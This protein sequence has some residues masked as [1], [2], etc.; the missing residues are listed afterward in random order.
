MT[1]GQIV[2]VDVEIWPTS[3]VFEAGHRLALD[4]EAHDGSGSSMFL[5]NDP[6]DRSLS[7]PAGTNTLCAGGKYKSFLLLPVIP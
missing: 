5:H 7:K 4:I 6:E 2:P 1:P 3:M